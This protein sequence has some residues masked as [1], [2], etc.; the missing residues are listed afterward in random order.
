MGEAEK[1]IPA[2]INQNN[3]VLTIEALNN[4]AMAPVH[5]LFN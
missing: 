2:V 5:L 4:L 1:L 3:L